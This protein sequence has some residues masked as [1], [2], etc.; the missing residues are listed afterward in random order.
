[1]E[2][3]I[4]DGM[5]DIHDCNIV[6]NHHGACS[7]F[8]ELFDPF[9]RDFGP[10]G[11]KYSFIDFGESQLV[12]T[13][14]ATRLPADLRCHAD[15]AAPEL[16]KDDPVNMF[17]CDVYALGALLRKHIEHAEELVSGHTGYSG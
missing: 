2:F 12:H 6:M 14:G 7:K 15:T 9:P 16:F 4:F 11:V 5:Q 17:C 13:G 3:L 8:I 10:C 1:M